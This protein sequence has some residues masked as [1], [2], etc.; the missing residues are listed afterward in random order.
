MASGFR[1][2]KNNESNCRQKQLDSLF[3]FNNKASPCN[4][5]THCDAGIR[6]ERYAFLARLA[7]D[8]IHTD[9][10]IIALRMDVENITHT[11][12]E[13]VYSEVHTAVEPLQRLPVG[14]Q[15][16]FSPRISSLDAGAAQKTER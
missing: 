15:S 1:G 9:E 2:V 3:Y 10:E 4:A 6:T 7:K 16:A 12:R 8:M 13:T 11:C 14:T 5:H